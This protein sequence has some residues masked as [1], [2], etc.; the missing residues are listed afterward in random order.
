MMKNFA[1]YRPRTKEEAVGLLR[2]RVDSAPEETTGRDGLFGN[3]DPMALPANLRE[4]VRGDRCCHHGSLLSMVC[5]VKYL[6]VERGGFDRVAPVGYFL[7]SN[8]LPLAMML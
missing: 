5:L 3:P 8:C 4:V 7:A 2:L 6:P 1:Y